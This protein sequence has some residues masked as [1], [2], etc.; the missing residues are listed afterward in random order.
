MPVAPWAPR[1]AGSVRHSR[2]ATFEINLAC[3][4]RAESRQPRVLARGLAPALSPPSPLPPSRVAPRGWGCLSHIPLGSGAG[5][6]ANPSPQKNQ[7]SQ[8]RGAAAAIT[9]TAGS[10]SAKKKKKHKTKFFHLCASQSPLI[11]QQIVWDQVL[12]AFSS[13]KFSLPG[14]GQPGCLVAVE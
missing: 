8:P 2:P 14:G 4:P 5:L 12:K 6:R 11:H 10:S 7:R 3:S 1:Q 9:G 13:G